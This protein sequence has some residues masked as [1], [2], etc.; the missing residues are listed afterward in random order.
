MPQMAPLNWLSLLIFF[1]V[2]FMLL[3]SLNFY[4][5]L[6]TN[7]NTLVQSKNKLNLNWKCL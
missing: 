2:I 3:N 6:Y 5:F 7:K 1:I 4:S